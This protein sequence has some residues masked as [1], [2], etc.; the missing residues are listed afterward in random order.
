MFRGWTG[1]LLWKFKV[2]PPPTFWVVWSSETGG[3]KRRSGAAFGRRGPPPGEPGCQG[4]EGC[5][6]WE[7]I[8]K[9]NSEWF[10][11]WIKIPAVFTPERERKK[12]LTQPR[13]AAYKLSHAGENLHLNRSRIK[14]DFATAEDINALILKVWGSWGVFR[15]LIAC[16]E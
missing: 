11:W 14:L 2:V 1:S 8:Y 10:F 7:G 15:L 4:S 3:L 9:W 16:A 12:S 13:K 5:P 6:A